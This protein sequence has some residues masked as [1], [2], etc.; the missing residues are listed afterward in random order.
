MEEKKNNEILEIE[1]EKLGEEIEQ[2]YSF[3]TNLHPLSVV[4]V[5]IALVAGATYL[6][7]GGAY[8][9]VPITIMGLD[10][11][12][13]IP[14][15]FHYVD[16]IPQSFTRIWTSFMKGAVE[17]SDISFTILL[18]T[19]AFTAIIATGA[20]NNGI[21]SLAKRFG[22][23]SIA[24]IPIFVFAF[25]LGGATYGMY[26]DAIP[27]IMVLCPLML[28]M[29]YDSLVGVMTV[30][31]AV[32]VGSSAA[33]LNPFSIG[34]AQALAE[35]PMMSGSGVRVLVWF[36][37]MV[38][39][40]IYIM[41]YALKVKKDPSKSLTKEEDKINR[42]K[43]NDFSMEGIEG[44]RKRDSIVLI[45]TFLAMGIMIYG[46]IKREWW[47]NE[48][49]S[50]FLF[51]GVIIS[52]IGGLKIN[53]IIEKNLEGMTT[54]IAAVLL[55]SA[56]RVITAMLTDSKVMD[57]ILYFISG[58]LGELPKS[59]AVVIMAFVSGISMIFIQSSS[60]CAAT[61]MP[62][63][64]PL[65]DI[66]GVP[67]QTICSAFAMFSFGWLVPWEGINYAMCRMANINFFVYL[68]KSIHFTAVVYLPLA[69]LTLVLMTI[70]NYS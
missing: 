51:M 32:V 7:P 59:I 49:G 17:A 29:G 11:E 58:A 28:M 46:V 26:E 36:V 70:F 14:G 33:V 16:S 41:R 25:G 30:H 22:N 39:T 57:T 55:I 56:S 2:K 6:I 5:I 24:L 23:K 68:K 60:G 42:I 43:Y 20:I 15:S 66:I 18:C 4:F 34:I 19:G 8:D 61:L 12:M 50:I 35:I 37:M 13:I 27:F 47:F 63:M 44:L 65:G 64:A 54:V 9:R 67:R 3:I 38:A 69:I 21:H 31:Y 10:R 48:I 45:L 52:L 53:E 62:I 1:Q 40:S